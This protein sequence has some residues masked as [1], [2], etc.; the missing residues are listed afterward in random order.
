MEI[1]ISASTN[2]FLREIVLTWNR[3]GP[4]HGME[5]LLCIAPWHGNSCWYEWACLVDSRATSP[6]FEVVRMRSSSE[7]VVSTS[8]TFR[9]SSMSPTASAPKKSSRLFTKSP[10][11]FLERPAAPSSWRTRTSRRLD[12]RVSFIAE[13]ETPSVHLG[14]PASC[15]R[16]RA[17]NQRFVHSLPGDFFE[18]PLSR[19]A[20]RV[21]FDRQ[22]KSEN[23]IGAKW[24]RRSSTRSKRT[25]TTASRGSWTGFRTTT[26]RTSRAFSAWWR[27]WRIW[28]VERTPTCIITFKRKAWCSFSSP[29]AIWI[30][31]WSE[32]WAW[33][34]S[35]ACGIRIWANRTGL[36]CS[37]SMCVLS[38][39]SSRMTNWWRRTSS[40]CLFICR[41]LPRRIGAIRKWRN[42]F[43]KRGDVKR[44][45]GVGLFLNR[46]L[47]RPVFGVF[48]GNNVISRRNGCWWVMDEWIAVPCLRIRWSF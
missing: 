20:F 39:W 48:V 29:S 35:F 40:R 3:C 7:S 31:C 15:M 38:F 47:K 26:R 32:S 4:W 42:C 10:S 27:S 18:R 41:I 11:M 16:L 14:E 12:R 2:D 8:S 45:W 22:I 43:R 1:K 33:R 46:C 24:T 19:L 21:V 36:M 30:V 9:V 28:C 34:R 25:R 13:I 23:W 37:M 6:R 17:R 44:G 5:S